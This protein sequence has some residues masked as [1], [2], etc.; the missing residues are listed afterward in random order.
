MKA[1][2]VPIWYVVWHDASHPVGAWQDFNEQGKATPLEVVTIGHLV[3][4]D[5]HQVKLA[6]TIDRDDDG[7]VGQF[8]AEITIPRSCIISIEVLKRSAPEDWSVTQTKSRRK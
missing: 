8:T 3:Y 6:A 4:K 5:K 1:A 7:D 2:N